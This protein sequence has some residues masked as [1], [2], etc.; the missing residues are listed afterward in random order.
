MKKQERERGRELGQRDTTHAMN[1]GCSDYYCDCHDLLKAALD[2]RD[3]IIRR[4]IE[5]GSDGC[6][7]FTILDVN[8]EKQWQAVKADAEKLLEGRE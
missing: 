4:L 7:P 1:A 8:F 6:E 3:R 5:L 2:E